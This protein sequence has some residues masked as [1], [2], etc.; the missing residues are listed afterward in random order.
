MKT[1]GPKPWLMPQPVLIIGTYNPTTGQPVAM[2]AAWGGQ[3]DANEVMISLGPH[4][5]TDNLEANPEFTLTFA[6]TNTLVAADYVG[7]VSARKVPDKLTRTGWTVEKAPH[8][9]APLFT[10][11]PLTLECRVK[12]RIGETNDGFNLIGEIIDIVL[13]DEAYL[14]SDGRPD[15]SKM[16]LIVFDP[17]RHG[18]Y[19]IGE[20]A[21]QAF[22][23]GKKLMKG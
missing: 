12:E 10:D 15:I 21:G 14:A 8:I 4:A 23:D 20:K 1:F 22:S 16:G 17:I 18:Y 6:T 2:N 5:T 9:D 3:W 11:F 13:T 19:A 7:L